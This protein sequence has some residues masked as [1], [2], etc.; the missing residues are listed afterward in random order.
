MARELVTRVLSQRRA[1]LTQRL[2]LV[3]CDRRDVAEVVVNVARKL[4]GAIE[5]ERLLQRLLRLVVALEFVQRE[6][7]VVVRARV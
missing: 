2:F 6:P 7:S 4:A 5:L 3:S 1:V